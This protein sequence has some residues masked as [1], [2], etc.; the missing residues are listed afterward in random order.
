MAK[1]PHPQPGKRKLIFEVRLLQIALAV[2]VGLLLAGGIAAWQMHKDEARRLELRE[3][4]MHPVPGDAIGGPFTLTDQDGKTVRDIDFRGKYMLVY[5]GYTY[6][7][8]LCPTG[9]EGLAHMLD[10]L[11]KDASKVQTIFITID[12]A[13]DTPAKLKEYVASFH[14]SIIGLTGTSEQIDAVA[15]EYKVYYARGENVDEN[16]YIMDHST[17]IYVMSP[18]GAFLMPFPD[19]SDPATMAATLRALWAGKVPMSLPKT[20][21]NTPSN[22]APMQGM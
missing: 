11:G 17:L 16:D 8:D 4:A 20:S 21:P 15:K 18:N 5:F 1:S 19:D 13:R 22:P 2:L 14:P 9:L 7:P 6:C 10:L 3:E 12:P